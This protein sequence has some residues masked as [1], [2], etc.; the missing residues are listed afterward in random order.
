[1]VGRE[2][3]EDVLLSGEEGGPFLT[4]DG[5]DGEDCSGRKES[6]RRVSSARPEARRVVPKA[7]EL[8]R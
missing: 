2:G 6:W 3:L 8:F 5:D 7:D 4:S 1:M